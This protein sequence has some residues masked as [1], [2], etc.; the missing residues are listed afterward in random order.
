MVLLMAAKIA[1]KADNAKQMGDKSIKIPYLFCIVFYLPYICKRNYFEHVFPR[2][3]TY[4]INL[5]NGKD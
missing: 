4:L 3:N 2:E 5:N 1:E